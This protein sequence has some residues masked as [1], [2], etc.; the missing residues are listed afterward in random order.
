VYVYYGGVSLGPQNW[1]QLL[2]LLLLAALVFA[3]RE[4]TGSAPPTP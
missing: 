4:A 1:K 3:C 2:V